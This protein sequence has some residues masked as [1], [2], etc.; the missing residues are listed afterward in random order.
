[1]PSFAPGLAALVGL[2]VGIGYALFVVTRRRPALRAGSAPHGAA[3]A[4]MATCGPGELVVPHLRA[5]GSQASTGV[6]TNTGIVLVVF[7]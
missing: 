4:A 3:A 7:S 5:R 6:R 1:V 2:G